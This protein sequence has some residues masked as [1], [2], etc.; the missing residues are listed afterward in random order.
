MDNQF[1]SID[2]VI[3]DTKT[4]LDW[5]FST[6]GPMTWEDAIQLFRSEIFKFWRFPT[7]EELISLVDYNLISPATKF[8]YQD[9]KI[10]WFSSELAGTSL[11]AWSVDF[12]IGEVRA[13]HKKTKCLLRPVRQSQ[14][15]EYKDIYCAPY[16][17]FRLMNIKRNK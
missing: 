15:D 17:N 7:I 8:P 14:I 3:F 6:F 5:H 1:R 10:F 11:D 13:I 2:G 4:G 12:L 9:H 16:V